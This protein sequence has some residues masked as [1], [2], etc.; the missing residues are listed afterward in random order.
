MP[1][2]GWS[3]TLAKDVLLDTGVL[4]VGATA[5][6]VS[7]GGLSFDPAKELRNIE[8]DG[9]KSPLLGLDRYTKFATVISGTMIELGQADVGGFYEPGSTSTFA[10]ATAVTGVITPK[11]A[12]ILLVPG[13]YLTNLALVCERADGTG[14]VRWR[15]PKAVCRKYGP[16]K[17]ID[18]EE[19]EVP[20]E[21]AA[22]LDMGASGATI[23]DSPYVYEGVATATGA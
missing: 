11:K 7:R 12:G 13:D 23:G 14:F 20:V 15:F 18:G 8:F 5:I 1:I 10:S 6:G 4:F 21:F 16:V 17:G 2:S 3:S 9:K 22:V 19:F